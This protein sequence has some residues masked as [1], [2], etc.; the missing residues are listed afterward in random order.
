MEIVIG[1]VLLLV[2]LAVVAVVV[3]R[4]KP[5]PRPEAPETEETDVRIRDGR[6]TVRLDV[7]AGDPDSPVVQ[8]LVH[9]AAVQVF[10][11]HADV[12]DVEVQ[13]ASGTTLGTVSRTVMDSPE[14]S[15]PA[16]I[17]DPRVGTRR[18]E[19]TGGTP[20]GGPADLQPGDEP[21]ART[22]AER[23]DLPE[24]VRS[25]LRSP[26]DVRDLVRA[27]L[28]AAG[29]D[30]TVTNDVYKVGREA[31]VVVQS[32]LGRV[33]SD[34]ELNNA[35]LRF[36]SSGAGRGVVVTPGLMYPQDLRRRWAMA[37][38]LR[39][40]GPEGIQRMADA[41]ALGANPIRYA[42]GPVAT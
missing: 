33:V 20:G 27:L 11:A 39:H 42:T 26:D 37:P 1:I 3:S 19:P 41:V 14:T 6:A 13:G 23:F 38:N 34:E 21:G 8:R 5:G 16:G 10:T 15:M 36:Q 25:R 30:F 22:L 2:V 12:Q 17:A 29:L 28:E 9:D 35:F 18:T 31:I 32:E 4:N 40:A 24:S 7:T